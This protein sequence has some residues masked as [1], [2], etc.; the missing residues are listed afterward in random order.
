MASGP[1]KWEYC[2]LED[3]Q[4]GGFIA[5]KLIFFT[6]EGEKIESVAADQECTQR[7]MV[8]RKI[9][10]L[11]AEGWDMVGAGTTGQGSHAVYFKRKTA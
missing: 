8:A 3:V 5:S 4:G 7:N 6:A 10:Q 1:D 2:R 9:A 11:G